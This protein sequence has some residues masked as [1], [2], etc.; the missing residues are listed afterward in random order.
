MSL[1]VALLCGAVGAAV[2]LL[3]TRQRWSEGTA[4]VAGGPF[5]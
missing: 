1:A 3:A 2:A 4:T 5:P